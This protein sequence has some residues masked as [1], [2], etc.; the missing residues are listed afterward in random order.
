MLHYMLPIQNFFLLFEFK[1][2]AYSHLTL[3]LSHR[4]LLY[5]KFHST[6]LRQLKVYSETVLVF[7]VIYR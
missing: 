2:F 3:F 1:N 4:P 7:H 6:S 5:P